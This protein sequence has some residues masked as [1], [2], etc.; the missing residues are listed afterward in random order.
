M[1]LGIAGILFYIPMFVAGPLLIIAIERNNRTY[2]TAY[3]A[4]VGTFSVWQVASSVYDVVVA[5]ANDSNKA[6]Y[7]WTSPNHVLTDIMGASNKVHL[8]LT[9]G[10][11][12]FLLFFVNIGVLVDVSNYRKF[13]MNQAT[14]FGSSEE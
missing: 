12:G 7:Y 11:A 5:S 10:A 4:I 14:I 13:Q 6:Q 8:M 1:V 2:V 9:T 3:L